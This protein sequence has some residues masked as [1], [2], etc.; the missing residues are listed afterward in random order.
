MY[1]LF[2]LFSVALYLW[3]RRWQRQ[4]RFPPGPP[5]DFLT[6]NLR[7]LPPTHSWHYFTKLKREY[8]ELLGLIFGIVATLKIYPHSRRRIALGHPR[9]GPH[10][11]QLVQG[12]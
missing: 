6:G 12:C 4:R 7:Q 9:A 1:L 5:K 2:L 10:H 8:G 3:H 11:P